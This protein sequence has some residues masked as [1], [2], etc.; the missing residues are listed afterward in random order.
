MRT[1]CPVSRQRTL[2]AA[3]LPDSKQNGDK[4]AAGSHDVSP[5]Q[6]RGGL[7]RETCR[8]SRLLARAGLRNHHHVTSP[9]GEPNPTALC[10]FLEN[11]VEKYT[12]GYRP[13]S[14]PPKIT[15]LLG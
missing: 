1:R 3:V 11:I 4:K 15:Y 14:L 6:Y 12:Q 13:A 10:L 5:L 7:L 8:L 9:A 2:G